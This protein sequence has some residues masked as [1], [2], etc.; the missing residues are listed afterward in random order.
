MKNL[1]SIFRALFLLPLLFLMPM[2]V[3]AG[4]GDLDSAFGN[5]GKVITSPDGSNQ[6]WGN[7]IAVQADGKI[8]MSGD[9]GATPNS[10]M[11]V[12]YNADGSPDSSFASNGVIL[13]PFAGIQIQNARVVIQA[14]GKIVVASTLFTGTNPAITDIAVARLNSN[15]SLDTSFDGDGKA[16]VDF[17]EVLTAT[18]AE[19]ITTIKL[20]PDGKIVI[21]AQAYAPNIGTNFVFAKLNVDGS[22]D[23]TFGTNGKFADVLHPAPNFDTLKD[24]AIL[25][26]GQLVAVGYLVGPTSGGNYRIAF[27]VNTAGTARD[28]SFQQ[29]AAGSAG[30][31]QSFNAAVALPDGKVIVAG[32]M[33]NKVTLWRFNTDGSIDVSFGNPPGTPTGQA[34]S[35]ALQAD[36]KIV[37]AVSGSPYHSYSVVRYEATGALDT[38]FGANGLATASLLGGGDNGLKVV[39][40]PDGKILVGGSTQTLSAPFQYYFGMVRYR[41]GEF[42]PDGRTEFDYDGDSRADVS[43]FRPSN[44]TWYLNRSTSGFTAVTFGYSTDRIVPADYDGDL[45][46][47]IAIYRDGQWWIMQSSNNAVWV[48]QFGIAEDVPQT[49]DYDGDDIDDIAVYRRSSNVWYVLRSTDRGYHSIEFGSA[50]DIP[51]RGD[52]DDD[53]KTDLAQFRPSDGNW[54]IQRSTGGYL[55]VHWGMAGDKPVASDFDGDNKL[56]FAVWRES[57]GDWYILR[58]SGLPFIRTNFGIGGDVPVPADYDGDGKSD[59]AVFRPSTNVWYQIL[60]S[61]GQWAGQVF[62][63]TADRPTPAAYTP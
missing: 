31:G 11:V 41:G 62:G 50:G 17:N 21:G 63:T 5:F 14:D 45:K 9:A 27:K 20:A 58:S 30:I 15:G 44:G 13:I 46:T 54:Y 25:P 24:I 19:Y 61:S 37:V 26:N 28:W 42:V 12:R 52:Y 18:Y 59:I 16:I 36:G 49:G 8:V 29:G 4:P 6:T 2:S 3:V 10:I 60:S 35:V 56:D 33:E 43:V 55:I 51:Q 1:A 53:G 40:A 48:A 22:P 39:I 57:T 47:D 34:N 23:M 32:R 7:G 38:T